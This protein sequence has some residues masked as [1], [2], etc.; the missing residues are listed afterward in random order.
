MTLQWAV[1]PQ[2][3]DSRAS[4]NGP[5]FSPTQLSPLLWLDAR[6]GITLGTGS[7]VA[8]W[9]DQSGNGTNFSQGTGANQ[10][11]LVAGSLGVN[12]GIPTVQFDGV[13]AYL[14]S[15][16]GAWPGTA[17]WIAALAQD[18]G[19]TNM[20]GGMF[21]AA[22]DAGIYSAAGAQYYA[23][24]SG[25]GPGNT[26]ITGASIS[27]WQVVQVTYAS[28]SSTSGT[29]FYQ[30][31][32]AQTL[33]AGAGVAVLTGAATAS[34]GWRNDGVPARRWKGNLGALLVFGYAPSAAQLLQVSRYL[35]ALGGIVVA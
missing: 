30:N 7:S 28:G 19:T 33:Y 1:N 11:L 13:N 12:G 20:I 18:T 27:T 10:P 31:G 9:A 23:D 15:A 24:G 25:T 16:T 32:V 5:A 3:L 26:A 29:Q 17:Q 2:P 22:G 21:G 8:G 14:L 34:V 35:G 6:F 4:A